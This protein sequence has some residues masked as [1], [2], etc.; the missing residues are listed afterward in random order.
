M[1]YLLMPL[2][3]SLHLAGISRIAV[4]HLIVGDQALCTFRQKHFVT[5]L[6]RFAHLAALDEIGV[7]FEDRV[8]LLLGGH[9]LSVYDS[10]PGLIDDSVSQLAVLHDLLS[11]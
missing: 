10:A 1:E 5:E 4:Q 11:E 7:G 6:Y 9:L 2:E 8:H 3:R